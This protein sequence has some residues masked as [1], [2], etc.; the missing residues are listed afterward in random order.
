MFSNGG[1]G[2]LGHPSPVLELQLTWFEHRMHQQFDRVHQTAVNVATGHLCQCCEHV[3]KEVRN[4]LIS[5]KE[6]K[7]TGGGGKECW[8][9]GVRALGVLEAADGLHFAPAMR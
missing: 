5:L 8:A 9:N 7:S 6:Q 2:T 4:E 3:P 1:A